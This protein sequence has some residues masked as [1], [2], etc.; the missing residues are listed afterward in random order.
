MLGTI[1]RWMTA[2]A[3]ALADQRESGLP[4]SRG[5]VQCALRP[6]VNTRIGRT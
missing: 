6:K 1:R 5:K 4:D 3:S 2:Q